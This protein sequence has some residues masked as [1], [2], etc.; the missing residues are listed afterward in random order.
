MH[1]KFSGFFVIWCFGGLTHPTGTRRLQI[2]ISTFWAEGLDSQNDT[3]LTDWET[4]P[5]VKQVNAYGDTVTYS[6][7]K[8]KAVPPDEEIILD[9]P[10]IIYQD[11][12]LL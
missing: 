11:S 4:I 3:N 6:I 9:D 12:Y 8:L 5:K 2:V 1:E 10:S 7:V